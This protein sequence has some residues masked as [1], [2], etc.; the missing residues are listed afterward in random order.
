MIWSNDETHCK[1]EFSLYYSKTESGNFIIFG[2]KSNINKLGQIVMVRD[3]DTLKKEQD[4]INY[5]IF[6]HLSN[7]ETEILPNTLVGPGIPYDK[8][9]EGFKDRL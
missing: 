7:G 9:P 2:A 8:T 6:G 3:Q 1:A 5:M 4:M